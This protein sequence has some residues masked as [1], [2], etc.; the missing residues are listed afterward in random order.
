MSPFSDPTDPRPPLPEWVQEAYRILVDAADGPRAEFT[1]GEAYA[2]LDAA[3]TFSPEHSDSEYAVERLLSRGYLY[4][5]NGT[6]RV[7][8]TTF[9]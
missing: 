8:E 3:E 1:Y 5:A 9:E 6:L 2:L 4:E 7:T